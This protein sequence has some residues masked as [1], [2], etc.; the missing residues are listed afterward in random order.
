M[1]FNYYC[2][3]AKYL[4]AA[5]EKALLAMTCL[6]GIHAGLLMLVSMLV[7]TG[8]SSGESD[9]QTYI[10]QLK[11]TKFPTNKSSQP[12][13]TTAPKPVTFKAGALRSPF[14]GATS[15]GLPKAVIMANPLLGYPL[16][17]LRFIG[18]MSQK[19]VDYAFILTP[20]NVVYQVKKG[21]SIGDRQGKVLEVK[22][23][24]LNISERVSQTGSTAGDRVVTLKLKEEH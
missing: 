12:I 7:L 4:F 22:E 19:N 15:L 6:C 2:H 1:A 18:T 3:S 8:C 13:S 5:L 23:S 21:D 9:L 11:Q 20:D 24:Q 14:E 17:M 10:E 16:T